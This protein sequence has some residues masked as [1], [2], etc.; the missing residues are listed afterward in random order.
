M[1]LKIIFFILFLIIFVFLILPLFFIGAP[2]LPS[3]KESSD[4]KYLE[5]LFE[6]LGKYRNKNSKFIDLGSGDGRIVIEFAKKNYESYGIEM[7]PF[8][9][10]L[11]KLKIRKEG[12]KNAKIIWGNFWKIDLSQFD[13]IY[14]FHYKLTNKFLTKKFLKQSKNKIIISSHFPLEDLKPQQIIGEFYVYFIT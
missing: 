9:V 10:F 11:S 13:I 3:Y 5:E 4:R 6:F 14:F 1:I 2:Y 8:L 12:L 7:N